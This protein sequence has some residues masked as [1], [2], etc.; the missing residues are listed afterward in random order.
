MNITKLSKNVSLMDMGNSTVLIKDDGCRISYM[1]IDSDLYDQDSFDEWDTLYE[2]KH[3]N[4][5]AIADALVK[6]VMSGCASRL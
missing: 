1:I 4:H 2:Y 5:G 3:V 6:Y